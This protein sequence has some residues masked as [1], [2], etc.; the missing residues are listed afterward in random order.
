MSIPEG[1]LFGSH[2]AKNIGG[3]TKKS[4]TR[5]ARD[6]WGGGNHRCRIAEG[7]LLGTKRY[8]I[9]EGVLGLFGDT[10]D[11]VPRNTAQAMK[12]LI[13]VVA[14]FQEYRWLFSFQM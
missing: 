14:G 5:V 6:R 11:I 1:G 7:G 13:I 8:R 4:D 9:A 10:G 3:P 12:P 2:T